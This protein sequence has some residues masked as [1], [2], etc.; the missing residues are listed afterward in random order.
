M[1]L[2]PTKPPNHPSI[3]KLENV[4]KLNGYGS[5]FNKDFAGVIN[6]YTASS[7]SPKMSDVA[8]TETKEP[9]K[10]DENGNKCSMAKAPGIELSAT[11]YGMKH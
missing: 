10:L 8:Q 7:R 1:S 6:D 5:N 9:R 3:K 4:K 2:I 11:F